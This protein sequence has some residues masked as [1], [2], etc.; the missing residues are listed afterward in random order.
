MYSA[1]SRSYELLDEAYNA[2]TKEEAIKYARQAIEIF[3]ENIDAECLIANYEEDQVVKLSKFETIIEKATEFLERNNYFNQNTIG[4]FWGILDTRP[5]MRARNRKV[6]ILI[7]LGRY[8][9][10]VKECEELLKL[11]ESDNL[12]V[13]YLLIGLYC[14]LEKFDECKKLFKKFDEESSTQLIFPMAIMYYKLG[15]YEKTKNILNRINEKNPHVLELL[16]NNV[17]LTKN[18][19]DVKY[20][21]PGS[22][23]EAIL[24]T[25]GLSYLLGSVPSFFT[26]VEKYF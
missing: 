6:L 18:L 4:H 12:G 11:C 24:V 17:Y 7:E 9:C 13:R 20:Y 21:S 23:E 3:P 14:L 16:K 25:K 22:I 5:Y 19:D 15:D 10:A 2:S 1:E 26:F 8:T